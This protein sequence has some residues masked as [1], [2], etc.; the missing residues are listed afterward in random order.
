MNPPRIKIGMNGRFFTNNW[1]PAV[2]EVAFAA[3]A[4]FQAIQF[5]GPEEGL[6]AAHLGGDLA[7]VR[8]RLREAAIVPVMEIVVRIDSPSGRTARGLTPLDVLQA[9]LPAITALGCACAHWHLVLRFP[10]SDAEAFAFEDDLY[11]P[12]EAGVALGRDL[13]FRFGIEQ[14]EPEWHPFKSPAACARALRAVEGLG[15]VWDLNHAVPGDVDKYLALAPRMQMLH[16]AD[17]PLPV[18][19]HHLPIG[20]GTVNFEAY[21]EALTRGGFAGPAILEIGGLPKSGGYGRDTD[22]ALIDSA[23]RLRACLS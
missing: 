14:N 20:Q 10:A 11:D 23:R 16:V 4:G 7:E 18:V 5:P 17:T 19:N 13:G 2:A 21:F 3:E 6:S 8:A 9:N 15:F 22:A 1:R 12:L